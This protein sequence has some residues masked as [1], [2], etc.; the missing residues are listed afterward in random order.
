MRYFVAFLVTIGLIILIFVLLLRG[1]GSGP[2]TPNID[3]NSYSTTDAIVEMVIDGPVNAE[4]T[5]RQVKIDV[6]Q[7]QAVL[8][9]YQGYQETVLR[10]KSYANNQSAFAVFLHALNI[11]GFTKGNPDK[12]LRDERGH[13]A[14]GNRYIFS[15]T[16]DGKE[17]ERYWTTSC[18]GGGTYKGNRA[19]TIDLFQK[20]IP[21]YNK[22]TANIP[23]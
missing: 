13:C 14:S 7:D 10:S 5:H 18:N 23:L 15:L 9:V 20:Q 16:N 11:N 1:G 22:L 4:Q 6:S 3:L 17:I 12:S 8:T 2:A 19:A 21:D